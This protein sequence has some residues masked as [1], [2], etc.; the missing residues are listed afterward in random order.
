MSTIEE[1]LET[2]TQPLL[3]RFMM[4]RNEV[5]DFWEEQVEVEEHELWCELVLNGIGGRTI[6]QA[7]RKS[8][9]KS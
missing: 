7:K 6:E 3:V 1:K 9:Q 5:N 2:F 4:L 8:L